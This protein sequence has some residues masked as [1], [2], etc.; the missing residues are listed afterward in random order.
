MTSSRAGHEVVQL[1]VR[2]P[3]ASRSRPL[4]QLKLSRRSP[5]SRQ[6][7]SAL[8]LR[9]PVRELDFHLDD[10]TYII[11]AGTIEVFVGGNSQAAPI[12]EA[13][14]TETIRIPVVESRAGS[15]PEQRNNLAD[16]RSTLRRA[17]NVV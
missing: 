7:R 2:D 13:H 6:R 14:I 15:R 17:A 9:V 1:Y 3:V 12:G 4:R 16:D 10:G 11:E 5:S 8:T